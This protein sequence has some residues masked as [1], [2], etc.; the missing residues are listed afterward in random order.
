MAANQLPENKEIYKK[1]TPHFLTLVGG[2]AV[3]AVSLP[4]SVIGVSTIASALTVVGLVGMVYGSVKV[5]KAKKEMDQNVFQEIKTYGTS[6]QKETVL[7]LEEKM[8]ALKKD[9]NPKMYGRAAAG[10]AILSGVGLL[11]TVGLG[12]VASAA[13]LYATRSKTINEERKN[14]TQKINDSNELA[15]QI[16]AR[17]LGQTQAP[18]KKSIVM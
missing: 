5:L 1:A 18:A 8:E 17:R 12:V 15:L 14:I 16:R 7:H 4:F 2:A 11:S 6:E 9:L 3:G 10:I 13:V